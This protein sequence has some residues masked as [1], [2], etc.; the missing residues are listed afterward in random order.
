MI[1]PFQVTTLSDSTG[2]FYL[3]LIPTDSLTPSGAKYEFT[4]VTSAGTVLRQRLAVP[5]SSSWQITW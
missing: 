5:D 1:S 3:D 2:Y 4:V